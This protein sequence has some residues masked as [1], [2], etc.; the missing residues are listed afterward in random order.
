M[1]GKMATQHARKLHLMDAGAHHALVHIET[2]APPEPPALGLPGKELKF[3]RYLIST[4]SGMYKQLA[5]R[6]GAD[7]G[8]DYAKALID[9][10]P[11]VDMERVGRPIRRSSTIYLDSGGDTLK[12]S[13]EVIE[14][15]FAPG[16]AERLRRQP[17]DTPAN[18]AEEL[19]V[20]WTGRRVKRAEALRKFAFKRTM[21]LSHVDEESYNFL[22]GMAKE[23]HEADMMVLI[24]A[25]SDGK[26]PLVFAVNGLS[27]RGFLEGRVDGA[28]YQLLLHLSNLELKKP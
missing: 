27:F 4:E 3:H 13:P 10:D 26:G 8:G 2:L 18:V 1:E 7:S 20:K 22:Y 23:L 6:Y 11:E 17:E 9:G 5:A 25:G 16:G 14:I 28:R 15:L 24:G 19:P 21:Q 12:I